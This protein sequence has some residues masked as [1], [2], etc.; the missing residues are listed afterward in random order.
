MAKWIHKYD[1]KF[2]SL[3]K[4]I[5]TSL[6]TYLLKISWNEEDGIFNESH[7]IDIQNSEFKEELLSFATG[8]TT[9]C[10]SSFGLQDID[11]YK[12]NEGKFAITHSPHEGLNL[13]FIFADGEFEKLIGLLSF[14]F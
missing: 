2:D 6:S 10:F 1:V 9:R 13:Q 4:K 12:T 5:P 11:F 3:Y 7:Q 14:D 8:K